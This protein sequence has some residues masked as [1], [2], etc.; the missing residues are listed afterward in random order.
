MSELK[1]PKNYGLLLRIYSSEGNKMLIHGLETPQRFFGS[2]PMGHIFA[3]Y[4]AIADDTLA[5][6]TSLVKIWKPGKKVQCLLWL[7]KLTSIM[8]VQQ[9]VKA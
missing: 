7:T 2:S 6:L 8:R 3:Y 9:R 5:K 4:S 1:G